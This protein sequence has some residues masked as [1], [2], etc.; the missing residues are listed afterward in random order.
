M[1]K[2]DKYISQ[3]LAKKIHVK[4]KEKGFELPESEYWHVSYLNL[5]KLEYNIYSN[6][7][8]KKAKKGGWMFNIVAS[9]YDTSE[10]GEILKEYELECIWFEEKNK[11]GAFQTC[12]GI[13]PQ[14]AKNEAEAR[15]LL[16]YYLLEN[17]LL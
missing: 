12:S 14:Y 1:N 13:V 17:D 2:T 16:F 10:L 4:A 7:E 8:I 5:G 15:G 11:F 3:P 9:A 6:E